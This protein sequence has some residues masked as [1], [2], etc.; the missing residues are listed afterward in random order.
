MAMLVGAGSASAHITAYPTLGGGGSEALVRFSISHGC[1]DAGTTK[2]EMQFPK[3]ILSVRPVSDERWT[4]SGGSAYETAAG[5][6]HGDDHGDE[7]SG[8]DKEASDSESASA[9][10]T[11]V[12]WTAK[13]A[14]ASE[15][16]GVVEAWVVLPQEAD[17]EI[18]MPTVQTCEDGETNDWTTKETGAETPAPFIDPAALVTH[19]EAMHDDEAAAGDGDSGDDADGAAEETDP[20]SVIALVVAAFAVMLALIGI[21]RSRTVRRTKD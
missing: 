21:L 12:T 2:L 16:L 4:G 17:G 19:D 3:E 14:V 13:P 20:V 9:D 5:H 10:G 18:W 1:D 11:V 6:S 8:E 7:H 15:D